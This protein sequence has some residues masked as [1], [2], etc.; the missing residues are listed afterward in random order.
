MALRK[1]LQRHQE[2]RSDVLRSSHYPGN[3]TRAGLRWSSVDAIGS[4][5]LE[6][7][8]GPEEEGRKIA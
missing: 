2:G 6:A 1:A 8:E 7:A 5:K 3:V 4:S